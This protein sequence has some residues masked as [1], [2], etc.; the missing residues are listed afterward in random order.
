[1]DGFAGFKLCFMGLLSGVYN[2]VPWEVPWVGFAGLTV[3][4]NGWFK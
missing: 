3:R 1:M 4:L 2:E